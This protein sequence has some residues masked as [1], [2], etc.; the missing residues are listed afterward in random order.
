MN[1][2]A[3][4]S[5]SIFPLGIAI[6]AI[7]I[8]LALPSTW[9]SAGAIGNRQ[10]NTT[11]LTQTPTQDEGICKVGAA[12]P[13]APTQGNSG[14]QPASAN[15]SGNGAV[16]AVLFWMQGCPHCETLMNTVLPPLQQK[17]G[18]K[19]KIQFVEL[20]GAQDVDRLYQVGSR[21][22][23]AKNDVGV[24]FLILGEQ[25]LVG[26]QVIQAKLTSVIDQGLAQGGVDSPSVP[27]FNLVGGNVTAPVNT[28]NKAAIYLFWGD[29]CPHCAEAK[30]FLQEL[31]QASGQVDL[32]MYEVWYVE[33]N[34][35]LFTKMAAAYGFEPQGVPTIF[36]GKQYWE[37]YND[38]IK[39]E[40]QEAVNA[41]LVS[42][43]PDAGVGIIPGVMDAA[44]APLTAQ[45]DLAQTTGKRIDIPLIG[46]V[47][48][49]SQSLLV[50]TLLIS[51]V[52]GV[53][54][55]SVWVLTM[56]LALTLHT[57][58]RK[59][60]LTIGLIFLTVTAGVYALFIAGLFTMFK[61]VSFVG[62]IQAVVA[63]VALFFAL[64]NIK[65]YFWYKEGI[66]FTIA[67]EK[68]PGIF[69]RIRRIMDASQSFWGLA[70]GTIVLAGGVSLV[71]F[72]CTAG[73]PVLWTNLLVAQNVP[74]LTFVFLLLV[75]LLIYQLDEMG[76][77]FAAVFTMRASKLEEKHGRILK[78]IGGML[79][80]ALAGVMLIKPSL[81]NN[82]GSSLIV[83]G[84][85]FG[86]TL[87]ILLL[88]RT[89]LP[90]Y[91]IRIGT[92]FTEKPRQK[93]RHAAGGAGRA[94]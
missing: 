86:A 46:T 35:A 30:P 87:I 19:L 94:H 6:L 14:Q 81:M 3:T 41:C 82:L 7:G 75:Y 13:C 70:G 53:N 4:R 56:L 39:G 25:P 78:L 5:K 20:N 23:I 74:A 33:E 34:Q 84:I 58:S 32:R 66:S 40:I 24:P 71:E 60:V 89:I 90:R 31:D 51:F 48:L 67:D 79:M 68:K 15:V 62:W 93:K 17:Y 69:Q 47:D 49:S 26:D 55:C 18:E 29:G 52:D 11:G 61:V 12:T 1:N 54:P 73:F 80:L 36:I 27:E 21:L 91:G 57:G 59:K 85:A 88:H 64:V 50:S 44:T 10:A 9:V 76:I 72:S 83:F 28:L 2:K 42:G 38:Q 65:D 63:L 37:G 8:F 43:C 77:F 45:P 92:E 16:N 22:G